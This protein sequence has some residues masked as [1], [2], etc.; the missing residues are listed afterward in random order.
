MKYGE[1]GVA[2]EGENA[3]GEDVVVSQPDP[4]YLYTNNHGFYRMEFILKR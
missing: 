3:V 2:G 4:G 1:S